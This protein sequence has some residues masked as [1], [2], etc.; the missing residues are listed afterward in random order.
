MD[1]NLQGSQGDTGAINPVDACGR[2]SGGVEDSEDET[3]LQGANSYI[4]HMGGHVMARWKTDGGN[5]GEER[6]TERWSRVKENSKQELES[7]E[8]MVLF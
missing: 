4:N 7:R 6:K 3:C 2:Y 8:G 5:K 1:C